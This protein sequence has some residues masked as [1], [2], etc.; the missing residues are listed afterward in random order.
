MCGGALSLRQRRLPGVG[1]RWS[2]RQWQPLA[3][4][5]RRRA[6]Q[7]RTASWQWRAGTCR[8]LWR[9]CASSQQPARTTCAQGGRPT[10]NGAQEQGGV[11]RGRLHTCLQ[12]RC[13]AGVRWLGSCAPCRRCRPRKRRAACRVAMADVYLTHKHDAAAYISCYK[14]LVVSNRGGQSPCH[15]SFERECCGGAAG[16]GGG[17]LVQ[18][19]ARGGWRAPAAAQSPGHHPDIPA[20]W[21][22]LCTSLG[23]MRPAAGTPCAA[24]VAMHAY[25]ACCTLALTASCTLMQPAPPLLPPPPPPARPRTCAGQAPRL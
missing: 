6:S 15:D 8:Q 11:P 18:G 22:L 4:P 23:A 17:W 25:S 13:L 2:L 5:R 1:C 10:T 3:A 14:D 16:G 7:W 9:S 20:M 19:G 21:A 12:L 24:S